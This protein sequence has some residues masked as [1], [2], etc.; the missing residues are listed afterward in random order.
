MALPVSF[1]SQTRN[2][3]SDEKSNW[4][5]AV[6]NVTAA[7]IAAVEGQIATLE[8][9][10][11]AISLCSKV[12]GNLTALRTLNAGAVPTN[13]QA[14]REKKWLVRYTGDATFK[15]FTVEIPGADLSLLSSA[16]Q[17]DFMDSSL[18]AYTD[19][20]AAF[21]A[22]VRSPDDPTETVTVRD[23]QFVG[24]QG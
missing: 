11:N 21:E 13:P 4:S 5:V 8:T 24:R 23:I 19:F 2:D 1:F 3:Y 7:N 17:S 15:K 18:T 12:K 14:Q 16:P 22:V 9:A 6:P 20:V 10:V